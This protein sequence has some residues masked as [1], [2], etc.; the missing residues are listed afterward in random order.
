MC[1]LYWLLLWTKSDKPP[2]F[3][4][5]QL[6]KWSA[7]DESGAFGQTEFVR[8]YMELCMQVRHGG[9]VDVDPAVRRSC[10]AGAAESAEG[11]KFAYESQLAD[12]GFL[13]QLPLEDW[14]VNDGAFFLALL[15]PSELFSVHR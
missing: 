8:A 4:M 13:F 6:S 10:E 2:V 7:Q 5:C 15:L 1:K 12:A 3:E 11:F 9:W 14:S